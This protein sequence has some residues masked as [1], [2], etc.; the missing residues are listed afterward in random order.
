MW[1]I[2][3][4][5]V[6]TVSV[7]LLPLGNSDRFLGGGPKNYT[8]LPIIFSWANFD[9]EHFLSIAVFGYNERQQAF[10]P[11]YPGLIAIIS[12]PFRTD[13]FSSLLFGTLAGIGVSAISFFF[14]LYFLFKL[15]RI[16]YSEKI[17]WWVIYL[18]LIFPTSFFFGAVYSEALFLLEVILSFYFARNKRWGLAAIFGVLA[19]ATRV[20]GVIL[21]PALLIELYTQKGKVRDLI[22]ILCIPIGLIIYM[23]YQKINSGDPFAFYN[24]QFT[25]GEQRQSQIILLPQVIYRY[26]K[27]ILTVDITNPIYQTILLEFISGI[28]FILLPIIGYFKKVRYS[29]LVY[30]IIG[31]LLSPL[32][33]SFSSVP[34]YVIVLFPA[35]IVLSLLISSQTKLIR[36]AVIL[37]LIIFLIFESSLF[38]RG[39]WVA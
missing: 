12:Y 11:V 30:S 32:Q 36:I 15:I 8:N 26:F 5:G 10:F 20:F 23:I 1:R 37:I 14:A 39:Y 9:G 35:F 2:G 19:S 28:V 18:I 25:I 6:I 13:L 38:F 16:D 29:Y 34:R 22:K 33:G 17:S 3:L 24:L 21:L 4:L 27:M 31:V 7:L